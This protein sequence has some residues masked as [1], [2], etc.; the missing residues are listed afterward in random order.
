LRGVVIALPPG[1]RFDGAAVPAC[2]AGD[3]E[4]LALGA[5]ACPAASRIGGGTVT[6][7]TGLGRPGDPMRLTATFLN[8]GGGV[9][10]L[11]APA[12]APGALLVVH[13]AFR[14]PN[15]LAF[16][17]VPA[18]PGGPPD[19]G[20][21][22]RSVDVRLDLAG[23]AA[24]PFLRTPPRCG[25]SRRWVSVLTFA[26]ADRHLYA[27]RSTSPCGGRAP[28]SRGFSSFAGSCRMSG[29]VAFTP[30]L[31]VT[32]M[33][34]RQH[35]HAIGTCSGSFTDADGRRSE[36]T[37]APA[38]FDELASGPSVSCGLGTPR[39]SGTLT[40]PGGTI[41]FGFAERR[42]GP[43]VTGTASGRGGGSAFGFATISPSQSPAGILA[44]CG[45]AGLAGTAVDVLLRTTPSLS[46]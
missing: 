29:P 11:L 37:G 4:L 20:S 12:G 31:R 42:V 2:R 5:A 39:G 35:A 25:A 19:W 22:V 3:A 28:A 27:A 15:V 21:A 32:P 14:R 1:S 43:I 18:V 30:A 13:G 10:Q 23:T 34:V 40:L 46:G 38:A 24:H 16:P 26:T 9:L 36:L 41:A 6:A 45:G 17:S 8:A 33:P 7:I 44:A